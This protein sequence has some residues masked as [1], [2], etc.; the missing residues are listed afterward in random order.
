M[1]KPAEVARILKRSPSEQARALISA[2]SEDSTL[3][4]LSALLEAG[5]PADVRGA[6]GETA[7]MRAAGNGNVKVAH[8]LVLAGAD[9]DLKAED[10]RT[11]RKIASSSVKKLFVAAP[12]G[13]KRASA[14]PSPRDLVD[15]AK[16]VRRAGVAIASLLAHAAKLE[17]QTVYVVSLDVEDLKVNSEEA[18]TKVAAKTRG[19]AR[20]QMRFAPS[21]FGFRVPLVSKP[22]KGKLDT[23]PLA[24]KRK[25]DN[26]TEGDLVGELIVANKSLFSSKI[27]LTHDFKVIDPGHGY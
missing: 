4:M 25:N 2:A 6:E 14:A 23:A 9:P 11:A 19:K 3:D 21:R 7:L 13:A 27:S 10:G 20:D 17:G 8:R 18:F 15:D 5:V 24:I 22:L 12:A 26:R 1:P 16:V